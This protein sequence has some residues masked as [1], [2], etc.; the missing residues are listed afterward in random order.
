MFR[1]AGGALSRHSSQDNGL[2]G[3]FSS[4]ASKLEQV[5]CLLTPPAL[6]TQ[7]KTVRIYMTS[8]A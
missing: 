8:N 2:D 6:Q 3:P 4:A 1:E 5:P 7:H